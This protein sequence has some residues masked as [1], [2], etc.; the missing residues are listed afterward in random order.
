MGVRLPHKNI[1]IPKRLPLSTFRVLESIY[2]KFEISG[3][4]RIFQYYLA[5]VAAEKGGG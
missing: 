4:R 1:F 3:F 5:A 2:L